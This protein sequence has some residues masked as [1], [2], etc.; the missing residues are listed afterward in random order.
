MTP[1]FLKNGSIN[2]LLKKV[3]LDYSRKKT[4]RGA[5]LRI[6]FSEN[7]PGNFR[8]LTLPLEIPEQAFTPRNSTKL[9]DTPWKLQGQKARF[10]EIP[11]E[12]FLEYLWKFRFSFN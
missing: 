4:N 9:C 10:T 11:H 12:F 1:T 2:N 3:V 6:Y 5:G 8:F 7:P